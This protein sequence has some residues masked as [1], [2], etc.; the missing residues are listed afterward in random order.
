MVRKRNSLATTDI[1]NTKLTA[2][3]KTVLSDQKDCFLR[4]NFNDR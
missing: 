3:T 1:G 4:K 2:Q